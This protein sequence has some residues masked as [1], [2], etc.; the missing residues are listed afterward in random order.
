[1]CIVGCIICRNRLRETVRKFINAP[2]ASEVI[3]TRG[4]TESANLV[5]SSFA[6]AFMNEG[7]EVII[8]TFCWLLVTG[9]CG[10]RNVMVPGA[11]VCT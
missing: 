2:S 7:D 11:S 3:F 5:V 8:S 6:E 1:M 10:I 9:G 4:T